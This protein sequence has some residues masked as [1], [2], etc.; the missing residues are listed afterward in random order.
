MLLLPNIT[1]QVIE[2]HRTGKIRILAVNAPARH[3]ALPEI[4][5]AVEAGVAG[6]IVQNFFGV[7]GPAGTPK[8]IIDLL[9]KEV[10]AIQDKPEVQKQM[11]DRGAFVQK[12]SPAEFRSHIEK[13]TAKWG[14]VVK[15][16]GI[17][18]Q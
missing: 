1:G 5:T 16:A 8:A 18:P 7:F 10:S 2:L 12:M 14:K 9:H 4:P 6:M 11:L 13:E 15:D 17:Q 3:P